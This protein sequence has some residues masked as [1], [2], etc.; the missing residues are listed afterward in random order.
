MIKINLYR[1]KFLIKLSAYAY[2]IRHLF[3]INAFFMLLTL[4]IGMI[5]PLLYQILIDRVILNGEI[6]QLYIVV[7][8]YLSFFAFS[9]GIGYIQN[10]INN[11]ITNSM[12]F[13]IK[14]K[15]WR[16]LFKYSAKDYNRVD[17]GD[18]KMKMENLMQLQRIYLKDIKNNNQY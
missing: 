16:N 17:K 12:T 18:I 11:R 15:I 13:R 5:T 6:N 2:G 4:A 9:A 14:Y 3:F 1:W 7:I 10:Y 8:G